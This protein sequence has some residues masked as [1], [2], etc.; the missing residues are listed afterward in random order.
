M[1]HSSRG[2]KVG[3]GTSMSTAEAKFL[4]MITK[5]MVE[6][7]H[8]KYVEEVI[9]PASPKSQSKWSKKEET[10]V[11][12]V[13]K[14]IAPDMPKQQCEGERKARRGT[15]V[16][17]VV[18]AAVAKERLRKSIAKRLTDLS[19]SEVKFLTTLV[20]SDDVT[21]EQLENA[22][23]ILDNDPMYNPNLWQKDE[24]FAIA[25]H[26]EEEIEARRRKTLDKQFKLFDSNVSTRKLDCIEGLDASRHSRRS[27][28]RRRTSIIEAS[29]WKEIDN[30]LDQST[31]SRQFVHKG[32]MGS[33]KNKV[34]AGIEESVEFKQS[35]ST[36]S[37][38]HIKRLSSRA[39]EAI[40]P[41]LSAIPMELDGA[42]EDKMA[43]V[44]SCP[45][46]SEKEGSYSES[47]G[48]MLLQPFICCGMHQIDLNAE[49][50][51]PDVV[52]EEF[53]SLES[54]KRYLHLDIAG[55]S[56]YDNEQ[57]S[58]W[59]GAPEDYPILG[60]EKLDSD[61]NDPLDPHVLSPLLIK[62]LR[63]HLPFALKEENFWLKY[64]LVRDG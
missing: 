39:G 62:C 20:N 47:L 10:V 15:G 61:G 63:D 9:L 19:G 8:T 29:V 32:S 22:L 25:V 59:L 1:T 7:D 52:E 33:T 34:D 41:L 26:G 4:S 35:S 64:S 50:K 17:H 40:D 43:R 58:T 44:Q 38:R 16:F 28:S 18:K 5:N 14:K 54:K 48:N 2:Y 55:A 46:E 57:L 42:K 3:E 56:K 31:H 37:T 53:G 11:D 27:Q 60:L 30:A 51:K 21:S 24:D 49:K 36:H 6:F 45:Q 12:D 23:D 13:L